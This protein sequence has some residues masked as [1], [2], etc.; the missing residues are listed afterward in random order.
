MSPISL[1]VAIYTAV[2]LRLLYITNPKCE[3]KHHNSKSSYNLSFFFL[4]PH[5]NCFS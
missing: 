1:S 3:P 2:A 4:L 5:F